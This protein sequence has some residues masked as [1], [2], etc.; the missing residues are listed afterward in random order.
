[1]ARPATSEAP[2]RVRALVV[3]L[4]LALVLPLGTPAADASV[5]FG[6]VPVS[7]V[8]SGDI[9]WLASRGVTLGCNPPANTRF[10]PD[11]AVT[12][13]QMAAFLVRALGLPA[14]SD[15]F[16][17]VGGSVFERDIAA[18]ADAGITKGCNPPANTRFCPDDAVTRGQMAAFLVRALGLPAGSDSFDDVGGSVFE[19]DIA[20]L[21]DAGITKGCNPPANTRFCPDDAVTRGQMAAF[22]RRAL[23]DLPGVVRGGAVPVAGTD[24]TRQPSIS[25]DGRHIAFTVFAGDRSAIRVVDRG[26]TT[27]RDL[28]P[29]PSGTWYQHPMLSGDGKWILVEAGT[30]DGPLQLWLVERATGTHHVIDDDLHSGGGQDRYDIDHQGR[31]VVFTTAN[32]A[33]ISTPDAAAQMFRWD[34][35]SGQYA[36]LSVDASGGT[37]SQGAM[38]EGRL[39]D[40]GS[41]VM[42]AS[43]HPNMAVDTP[44]HG[45]IFPM[46]LYVHDFT[47]GETALVSRDASGPVGDVL[48]PAFSGSGGTVAYRI[49]SELVVRDL[50]SGN[51]RSVPTPP[52]VE[53]VNRTALSTD[54]SVLAYFAELDGRV[55]L[56]GWDSSTTRLLSRSSSGGA[57]DRDVLANIFDPGRPALSGSGEWTAFATDATNLG[58]SVPSG[59]VNGEMVVANVFVAETRPAR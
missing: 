27:H 1:M 11:D 25:D 44:G 5:R 57:S 29:G 22:V 13:G 4:V 31:Y 28:R 59:P 51:L 21:A 6:D 24:S 42:F 37:P 49:G 54:G 19:R 17:D 46:Y 18:L 2:V 55:Q 36:P 58:A 52:G 26:A 10:C 23:P 16:D 41:K 34:R 45:G 32:P 47:T 8:F 38:G 30:G 15:S 14:G 53:R 39:S 33:R 50:A 56:Y 40:D 3:A 12:R 20:A 9:D 48:Y 43:N 7:D 35:V